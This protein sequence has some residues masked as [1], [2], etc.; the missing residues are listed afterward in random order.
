MVSMIRTVYSGTRSL[1]GAVKDANRARQIALIVG[2]HGFAQLLEGRRARREEIEAARAEILAGGDAIEGPG[3][4]LARRV[5]NMIEELGPTFVKFGQILSSRP[6][7]IPPHYLARMERLQDQVAPLPLDTVRQIISAELGAAPEAVFARFDA[8]PLAAASIGQVHGARTHEGEEV[9]IKVQRPGLRALFAADISLLRF[10]AERV[11]EI[12]PE[13]AGID[14]VAMIDELEANLLRE[15]DFRNEAQALQRFAE[16]F[17]AKP[18]VHFP[19]VFPAWS[20]AQVLTMERIAGLKLTAL[21]DPAQCREAAQI[22]IDAAYQM[23][24]RDGLFHGDLHPGNVFLEADG[25]LGIIDVGM[26]GRLSRRRRDEL[27]DIIFALGNDDA[28]AVARIWYAI[29]DG[30]RAVDYPRFERAVV[31]LLERR[32]IGKGIDELELAA[33]FGDLVSSAGALGVRVPGDYLMLIKA[34]TTTEGLA[35]QIAAGINPL[36]AAK[37]YVA[38]LMRE[39]YS[40]RRLKQAALLE[41]ARLLEVAREAPHAI[42][43]LLHRLNSGELTLRVDAVDQRERDERWLRLGHTGVL[44][45]LTSAAG[46]TGALSVGSLGS[47]H[48]V[49]LISLALAYGGLVWVLWRI[50]RG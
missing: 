19:R 31:E 14:L 30:E 16:N 28:E 1:I 29:C 5:V 8:E 49:P 39:R 43:R 23:V 15:T 47:D 2:R 11:M 3:T 48:P 37:P 41:G 20:T 21:S 9:V 32:V 35:R 17:A 33:L 12:F 24:F 34:M 7:L 36:Q 46:L 10:F 26:V 18:Q 45:L 6:D 13:A 44:A 50:V 25:R 40:T 4:D 22:Y 42:E 38:A 27:V